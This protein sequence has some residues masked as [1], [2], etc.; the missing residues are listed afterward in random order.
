MNRSVINIINLL[1]ECDNFI[2]E[3][4]ISNILQITLYTT[5][6]YLI[7]IDSFLLSNSFSVLEKIP[8]CGI[9]IKLQEKEQIAL[10]IKSIKGFY[11]DIYNINHRQL[12]LFWNL[13]L[14]SNSNFNVVEN[15]KISKRT[16]FNDLLNLKKELL[17]YGIEIVKHNKK[18]VLK[19][20]VFVLR[21]ILISKIFQNFQID[22]FNDILNFYNEIMDINKQQG[23]LDNYFEK[24]LETFLP[25]SIDIQIRK[26]II[27]YIFILL[28]QYKNKIDIISFEDNVYNNPLLEIGFLQLI[29][30]FFLKLEVLY[31]VSIQHN[32]AYIF[33]VF[34][35]SILKI[36]SYRLSKLYPLELELLVIKFVKNV[37]KI[38]NVNF[39]SDLELHKNLLYHLFPLYF[40]IKF[41]KQEVNTLKL[42]IKKKYSNL[43]KAICASVFV[44]DGYFTSDI[45]DDEISFITVYFA[46]SLEKRIKNLYVPLKTLIVCTYGNAISRLLYYKIYNNYN[47][48]IVDSISEHQLLNYDLSNINLIIS[49]VDLSNYNLKNIKIVYISPLL[50][51]D[52]FMKLDR[53]ILKNEEIINNSEFEFFKLLP[54]QRFVYADCKK[55]S[56]IIELNGKLL[57]NDK[58]CTIEYIDELKY[59]A[60]D[61]NSLKK[62]MI[63]KGIIMPHAGI[64]NYALGVGFSLVLLQ[65]PII[66]DDLEIYCS[67]ALCINNKVEYID[68]MKQLAILLNFSDFIEEIKGIKSYIEFKRICMKYL[69]LKEI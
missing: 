13:M 16:F 33:Y 47:L 23:Y 40:R 60:K 59:V 28:I 41:N 12:V 65:K 43:Y 54:S 50:N 19:G 45:S 25:T 22:S 9:R 27:V 61:Y 42:E 4:E 24:L 53:I 52:D 63:A 30:N 7:D 39:Y 36:N 3:K 67:L 51:S 31:N 11:I 5:K 34:L 49:V 15:M 64:N 38:E 55:I 32:E 17:E 62:I 56:E 44:F 69:N 10:L 1:I 18:Y 6:K 46:A 37:S 57:L 66:V 58:I 21:N 48:D 29:R 8:H 14:N 20:D 35:N 26:Q 68:A 2:T